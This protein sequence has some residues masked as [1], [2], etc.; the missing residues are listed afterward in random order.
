LYSVEDD[1]PNAFQILENVVVP[2][3]Q[4]AVAT[5]L[6]ASRAPDVAHHRVAFTMLAA[7]NFDNQFGLW[8]KEIDH[9]RTDRLLSPKSYSFHLV[10]AEYAPERPFGLGL[11]AP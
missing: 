7:I 10:L 1:L 2:K 9:E 11:R 3:A 4:N 6:K 8:A 5:R